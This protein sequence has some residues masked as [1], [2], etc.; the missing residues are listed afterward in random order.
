MAWH[1]VEKLIEQVGQ[2]STLIGKF[3]TT[4]FFV[5]RFLMVVSIA[6]TV[7]GDEQGSFV[8]NTLTPGCENV[9]FNDFSPI[10]LIR[11]WALQ[12]LSV[13][14]PS[15]IFIVYT[16][17]KLT[18]IEQARALKKKE[19]DKKKKQKEEAKKLREEA[20]NKARR[21]M[22][23]EGPPEYNNF[24]HGENG[25]V[26]NV[27]PVTEKAAK[28]ASE[29]EDK[30]KKDDDKDDSKKDEVVATKLGADTPPRL[31]LAYLTQVVFR[32]LVEVAFMIVQ[33][34]IYVYK[35]Y[36][37]ELFK[38]S[39]WPC[40]NVVDCFVSRPKEKTVMLWIMFGTGLIMIALNL[41]ELYHL[42]MRQAYDAWKRR[43]EDITKQ[44]KS[45]TNNMPHF[46]HGGYGGYSRYRGGYPQAVGIR[47]GYARSS[48][49]GEGGGDYDGDQFI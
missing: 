22:A 4:F 38:C 6:D 18:K 37:P 12:I 17:H 45:V 1:I 13:A 3:W 36:V 25:H 32:L 19:E 24:I 2:H 42:G 21:R 30:K 47:V 39:R 40:P 27:E 5:L 48:M 10:S 9:C 43:G 33:F 11:L 8:C 7:F 14:I 49:S 41:I 34:N 16:A 31:F 46:G 29:K 15:I 26:T 23:D 28:E 44:Y 20:R 35:F